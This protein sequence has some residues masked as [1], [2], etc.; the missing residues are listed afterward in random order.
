[1]FVKYNYGEENG[2]NIL[3]TITVVAVPNG[4]LQAKYNPNARDTIWLA[5]RN[6]PKRGEEFRVRLNFSKLKQKA[7]WRVQIIPMLPE[8]FRWDF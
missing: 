6:S 7:S 1:M 5:G 3:K 8:D 4:M 2:A